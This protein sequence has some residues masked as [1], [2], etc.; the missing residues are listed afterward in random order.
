MADLQTKYLGLELKNPVIA[1]ASHMTANVASIQK[2]EEQGAAAIVC[3]SLFEEQIQLERYKLEEA[4]QEGTEAYAEMTSM[5]P[6]LKDAGPEEHLMWIQK[7]KEAVSVPVIASLNAVNHETWLEYALKLEQTGAD[8][9]ELNF[10]A[11]P[12]DPERPGADVEMEQI[13]ILKEIKE[14]ISLP[15]SVKLSQFYS[16]PLHFIHQL[17]SVGI[18]GVVVFNRLFQPDID[19]EIEASSYP[20]NLSD[21]KDIR[22]PLRYAGLLYG[23]I[24]ADICASSGVFESEDA[25]KLLLAGANCV[26]VVSTL[27][28]N[29]ID[30]LGQIIDG[31]GK[32]MDGKGYSSLDDFVGKLSRKNS[33]DPWAYKRAQ[34]IKTVLKSNPLV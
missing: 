6:A 20:F 15:I 23:N 7:T 1:G 27:Y 4:L 31:L 21:T 25:V 9:L 29:G 5:F 24:K 8:A 30:Q 26:Q 16:N 32:W 34:Y 10:F 12:S 28:R 17:D 33:K 13:Q 22:L 14:K 19:P 18:D 2:L 11:V 3:K